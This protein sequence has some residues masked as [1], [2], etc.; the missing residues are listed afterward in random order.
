MPTIR[1]YSTQESAQ[2]GIPGRRAQASD[3]YVNPGIG[4]GLEDLATGLAEHESRQEVSDVRVR[5]AKARAERTVAL[6]KAW[7]EGSADG[8][9]VGQF[10]QETDAL[11]A[12]IGEGVRTAAGQRAFN[13][14][15]ASLSADMVER[16]GGFQA[17]L[18]GKKAVQDHLALVDADRNTLLAD[19][20]Q[21]DRLL[22]E[23]GKALADS[24]G[25]YA[26]IDPATRETLSREMRAEMA[27]S[28]VQGMIRVNPQEAL[29]QI[30]GGRYKDYLD[31]DVTPQLE[32]AAETAIRGERLEEERV[33]KARDE[34]L[35]REREEIEDDFIKRTVEDKFG[36]SPKEVALSNLD[37]D[38]KRLW[39]DR[40]EK[41]QKGEG[42]R[43]D[44]GVFKD[45]WDRIHLPF[46]HPL[47]ISD[48][49]ALNKYVGDGL[50]PDDAQKLRGEIAGTRTPEGKIE[51]QLK[52]GLEK[53]ARSMLTGSNPLL[54]LR[55]P[56]GD[57]Q[58]QRFM[59]WFLPE[60]ERQRAAGKSDLEL[61]D[62]E[63]KDYLGKG[64]GR[65]KRTP[66]Q[67]FKDMFEFNPLPGAPT[68]VSGA[69]AGAGAVVPSRPAG[70][71]EGA[72]FSPSQ[73]KWWWQEKNGSWRSN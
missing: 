28:A 31:A 55:D 60:Y 37:P 32:G 67:M 61:L 34:A 15:A 20:S 50:S 19:P 73:G 68:G 22:A 46:D 65:F 47:H 53:T 59:S 44:A 38:D 43:T 58:L 36:V 48:P 2:A 23:R 3:F 10:M 27:K 57:E 40:L 5:L 1:Q 26:L 30:Q 13:E 6:E 41:I 71:P 24:T 49:S 18:A 52:D 4:A 8:K 63:S 54:G 7:R 62:P 33:R 42:L 11:T 35:K 14:M 16:A 66:Q 51:A 9:W 72:Q 25:P 17:Q 39:I 70:V 64:I 45:L 21:F 29:K 12:K 69:P 56:K